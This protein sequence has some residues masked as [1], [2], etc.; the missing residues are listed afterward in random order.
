MPIVTGYSAVHEGI[1]QPVVI[2]RHGRVQCRDSWKDENRRRGTSL[3]IVT[4]Y[5]AVHEG[6]TQPATSAVQCLHGWRENTEVVVHLET[7]E[8]L[9]LPAK[10]TYLP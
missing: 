1:K 3:P 4:S 10:C 2:T 7:E 6:I 8:T 9:I 5:S